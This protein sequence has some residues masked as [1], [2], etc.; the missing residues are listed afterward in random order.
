MALRRALLLLVCGVACVGVA[1][2]IPRERAVAQLGAVRVDQDG[3]WNR[4]NGGD[5]PITAPS[6]SFPV[7]AN[8]LAA[9][10]SNGEPDK[11][12][13]VGVAL[14]VDPAAFQRLVLN[15]AEAT[16]QGANV[17]T[18]SNPAGGS[19]GGSVAAC[20]ITAAWTGA[21][22]GGW[23]ARPAADTTSCVIGSRSSDG[24][25]SFD[26]TVFARAWLDGSAPADGVLLVEQVD[27]PTT[28]QAAWGDRTTSAITFSLDLTSS[29]DTFAP[30][31]SPD[32]SG[33]SVAT[34]D[35]AGTA[36][37]DA[38]SATSTYTYSPAD[39]YTTP[40][41]VAAAPV[42][43]PKSTTTKTSSPAAAVTATPAAAR[44]P[45]VA[46][47]LPIALLLLVPLALGLA[48]VT[49]NALG[50]D[51][52]P[53]GTT[54]TRREGSVSRALARRQSLEDLP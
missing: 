40:S 18:T 12:A 53:S 52:D 43:T 34:G 33:G 10:A 49:A 3:W 30:V 22:N 11:V 37:T 28:F 7:P 1:T 13:A 25:W 21:K 9:S 44:A 16:D 35:T 50:A 20:R 2:A 14:E 45:D 32:D 31:T 39:S 17:G 42:P 8:A 41:P 26:I 38:G 54:V 23:T 47:N 29:D 27:P 36:P 6:L 51:G 4:A 24:V 19:V 15:L 5:V 48:L 46:G